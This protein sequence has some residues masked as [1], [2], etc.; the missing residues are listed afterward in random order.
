MFNPAYYHVGNNCT[1]FMSQAWHKAGQVFMD[2][3]TRDVGAYPNRWWADTSRETKNEM[4]NSN[5]GWASAEGFRDQQVA[6]QRAQNMGHLLAPDFQEGDVILLNWKESQG[7]TVPDHAVM[8]TLAD[9]SGRYV[10]S[11]TAARHHVSWNDYFTKIVPEFFSEKGH[12]A[13]Y[14]DGWTWEV[15]RPEWKASNLG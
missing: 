10:A 11:E 7:D 13:Q 6:S 4:E 3:W 9:G 12:K 1:N 2:E 15:I 14:P 5:W 8:V